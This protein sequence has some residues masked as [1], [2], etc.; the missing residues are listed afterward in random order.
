LSIGIVKDIVTLAKNKFGE[1]F[2]Q[3]IKPMSDYSL[4][5][6]QEV[7]ADPTICMISSLLHRWA[8]GTTGDFRANKVNSILREFG[9][10]AKMTDHI[11]DII[12]HLLPETHDRQV[13]LEEKVVGDAYILT[14][15]KKF[16]DYENISFNFEITEKIFHSVEE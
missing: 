9:F 11:N 7:R 13:T 2:T 6:A 15:W 16:V 4:K 1:E 3:Y 10:D 12:N 14:Y 8:E 5:I